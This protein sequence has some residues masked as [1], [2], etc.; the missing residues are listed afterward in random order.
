MTDDGPENGAAAR[1][2]VGPLLRYVDETAATIWV[3]TDRACQVEILGHQ[4]RTFEVSGHHYGLVVI[5]GLRAGTEHEYQVAL[6]GTVRWPEPGSEFPPS[7]LRT[8]DPGRPLRL[9]FG[10]CRIA[11]LPVL[12]AGGPGAGGR[13]A[14]SSAS[15]SADRTRWSPAPPCAGRPAS[16]GPTSCS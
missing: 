9:V 7:V 3:E 11:E 5:E 16:S 6:D 13:G 10:S 4:A 15:R 2:V 14:S 12:S 8:V 1:L